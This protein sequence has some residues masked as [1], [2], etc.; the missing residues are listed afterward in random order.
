MNIIY[1]LV[2][3]YWKLPGNVDS[4]SEKSEGKKGTEGETSYPN[5]A[6]DMLIGNEE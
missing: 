6:N 2:I 1:Y 4:G 5:R 3:I